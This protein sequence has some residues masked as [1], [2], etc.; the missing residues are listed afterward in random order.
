MAPDESR[1][2]ERLPKPTLTCRAADLG[3]QGTRPAGLGRNSERYRNRIRNG[4]LF[5]DSRVGY[6]RNWFSRTRTV[7]FAEIWRIE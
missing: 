6:V 7:E 5:F 2:L 3:D 4:A 1:S